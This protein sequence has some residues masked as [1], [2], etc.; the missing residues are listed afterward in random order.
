[1]D[2]LRVRW[3]R[4]HGGDEPPPRQAIQASE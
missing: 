3:A 2:R 4:K 1:M